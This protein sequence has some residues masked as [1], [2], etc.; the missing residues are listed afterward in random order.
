MTNL[1]TLTQLI[2]QFR[3]KE[4]SAQSKQ[5]SIQRKLAKFSLLICMLSTGWK[6]KLFQKKRNKTFT[7]GKLISR[8]KIFKCI[9]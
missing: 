2:N 1:T 4:R 7:E 8:S 9:L 6:M 5:Q 3:F